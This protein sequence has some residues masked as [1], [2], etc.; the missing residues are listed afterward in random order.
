MNYLI[1]GGN[2]FIGSAIREALLF[3]GHSVATFGLEAEPGLPPGNGSLR[4]IQGDFTTYRD[5]CSLLP[6]YPVVFH[7]ISTTTPHSADLRPD[8]DLES[9]VAALLRFLPE[10]VAARSKIVFVSSAGTVYGRT[11]DRYISETHS[12]N[13]ICAYGIGK[14]AMEKYLHFFHHRYG[15]V[16]C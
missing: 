15:L 16:Y 12:T 3:E 9:N 1:L 6:I 11:R 4:H 8:F 7:C 13:P 5:W 2:G 10:A 14:L